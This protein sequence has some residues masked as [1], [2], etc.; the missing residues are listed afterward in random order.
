MP[1]E[2]VLLRLL[3]G[4][5]LRRKQG[6]QSPSSPLAR[7]VFTGREEAERTSASSSLQGLAVQGPQD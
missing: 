4:N 5:L 1:R 7:C 2:E 6:M 3:Q